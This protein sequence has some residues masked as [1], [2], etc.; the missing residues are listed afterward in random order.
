MVRSQRAAQEAT[1]QLWTN[2]SWLFPDQK[3]ANGIHGNAMLSKDAASMSRLIIQGVGREEV[4]LRRKRTWFEMR[5]TGSA[6]ATPGL[7]NLTNQLLGLLIGRGT[8]RQEASLPPSLPLAPRLTLLMSSVTKGMPRPRRTELTGKSERPNGEGF[9]NSNAFAANELLHHH[10]QQQGK[11][12][13]Q[14]R[15]GQLLPNASLGPSR[16]VQSQSPG[17]PV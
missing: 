3:H 14:G 5:T 10:R 8:P 11:V 17:L 2:A 7:D 1:R 9:A 6:N 15:L 13:I 12:H 16:E 4:F